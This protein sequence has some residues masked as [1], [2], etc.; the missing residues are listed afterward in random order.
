LP[1]TEG[2][3][4]ANTLTAH[5]FDKYP[6]IEDGKGESIWDRF[7]HTP[8][9]I[10]DGSNADVACDH[11]HR[12]REDVRLMSKLSMKAYRF[13]I[14]WPRVLPAG[15]GAANPKGL[16]FY[17][18]L[19]DALLAAGIEPFVTL[20]HWDLPQKLQD[21]GGWANRDI[22]A[23]FEEYADAVSRRLGGRLGQRGCICGPGLRLVEVRRRAEP[24]GEPQYSAPAHSIA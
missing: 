18:R 15:K 5:L 4:K 7:S 3:A 1:D 6:A 10:A 12:Y 23:D 22:V 24:G 20:Y 17:D 14:S 16:D 13:S 8:G 9:K 11:Y 19:V 21:E 2:K